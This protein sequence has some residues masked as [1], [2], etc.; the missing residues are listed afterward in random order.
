MQ[1]D[2]TTKPGGAFGVYTDEE[3]DE[4]YVERIRRDTDDDAPDPRQCAPARKCV[5]FGVG[6]L[7]ITP[8]AQAALVA[9]KERIN[10]FIHRHAAGKWQQTRFD[11]REENHRAIR[12][13]RG[14]LSMHMLNDGSPLWAATE[15]DRS[16]TTF[17]LPREI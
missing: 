15:A 8:C 6:R 1:P 10:T 7:H 13:G 14:V 4:Q 2:S 11:E 5:R 12:E 9:T 16:R 17:F 3:L